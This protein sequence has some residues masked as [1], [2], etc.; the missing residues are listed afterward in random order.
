VRQS[1]S[2]RVARR[3]RLDAPIVQEELTMAERA[4]E[5][6]RLSAKIS[7]LTDTEVTELLE[8]VHIM[9][10]MRAQVDS[11]GLFEDELITILA[12]SKECR[13]ART[14]YEWDR[15]RRRAERVALFPFAPGFPV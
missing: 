15:V 5:R 4:N 3:E 10:S 1:S 11:P 8:Y 7:S 6:E 2:D 13:R 12:D 9:E 14:V